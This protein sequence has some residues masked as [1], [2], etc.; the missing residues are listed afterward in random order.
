[1][2]ISKKKGCVMASSV[3]LHVGLGMNE[4]KSEACWSASASATPI[5]ALAPV[6]SAHLPFHSLIIGN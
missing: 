4:S 3:V 5:P 2:V 1:M 6:I